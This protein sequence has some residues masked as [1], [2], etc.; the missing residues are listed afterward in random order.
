MTYPGNKGSRKLGSPEVVKK[1]PRLLCSDSPFSL[2]LLAHLSHPTAP[3]HFV[4]R[5][6]P[7]SW[8]ALLAHRGSGRGCGVPQGSTQTL[9]GEHVYAEH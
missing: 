5:I 4:L 7:S 8:T 1:G 2:S 3:R 9:S 6:E